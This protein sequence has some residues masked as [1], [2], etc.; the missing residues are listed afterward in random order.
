[1]DALRHHTAATWPL[2]DTVSRKK[3]RM[4]RLLRRRGVVSTGLLFATKKKQ[5][6]NLLDCK[7]KGAI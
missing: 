4:Q 2:M 6:N 3:Q 1:M 7:D 5:D